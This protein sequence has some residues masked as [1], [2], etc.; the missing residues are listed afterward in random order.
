MSEA[1]LRERKKQA[2]REALRLAAMRLAA[3]RGWEHVRVEDIAAEAGVSTRTFNNYF[4]SK[5]EAL[6]ATGHQRAERIAEA[7]AARPPGEPLWTALAHA[8]VDGFGMDRIDLRDIARFE[9]PPTLVEEHLKAFVVIE[10]RLAVAIAG[11][12]GADAEHDLYPV[13]AA[14]VAVS[15]IRA[16]LDHWRRT[17][18]TT[19]PAA[20]LLD[21]LDQVAAGLPVPA[22]L[23][24]PTSLPVSQRRK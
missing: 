11:R 22:G 13:L 4:A 23:P 12:I 6:L 1:G 24:A 16:A 18:A 3:E 9:T 5:E 14:G 19:S 7:L 2:T 15:T 21:V 20:V 10:R 17:G 8:V